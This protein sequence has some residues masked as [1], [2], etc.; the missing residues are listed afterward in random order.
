M[1]FRKGIEDGGIIEVGE[2]L[3]FGISL[4]YNHMVICQKWKMDVDC[5]FVVRMLFFVGMYG[6]ARSW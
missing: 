5:V 6:S 3:L 1:V 2:S 4:L